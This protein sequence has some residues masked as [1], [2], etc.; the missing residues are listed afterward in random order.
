MKNSRP[1]GRLFF[2]VSIKKG[3]RFGETDSLL[4]IKIYTRCKRFALL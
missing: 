1:F 4:Q 2:V 3:A